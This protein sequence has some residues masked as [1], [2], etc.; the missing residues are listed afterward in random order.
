MSMSD[1]G[2][3]TY[4]NL[5]IVSN[6]TFSYRRQL[7]DGSWRYAAPTRLGSRRRR[8]QAQPP[9]RAATTA[10][11]HAFDRMAIASS[12]YTKAAKQIG[13]PR[14]QAGLERGHERLGCPAQAESLRDRQRKLT[15]KLSRADAAAARTA[16]DLDRNLQCSAQAD[17]VCLDKWGACVPDSDP[18]HPDRRVA[19]ASGFR[20]KPIPGKAG[21]SKPGST[22]SLGTWR[23][24]FVTNISLE[25][26]LCLIP[27]GKYD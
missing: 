2:W 7:A 6:R 20:V 15:G 12:R 19:P 4:W 16:V 8:L 13:R 17:A 3:G 1:P 11:L 23:V 25:S 18:A 14:S 5:A 27:T 22:S 21:T 9:H 24:E 26:V 10:K